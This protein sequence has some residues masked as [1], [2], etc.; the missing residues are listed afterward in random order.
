MRHRACGVVIKRDEILMVRHVH[1]GRDYWTLPGGGIDDGESIFD[2][3]VREVI[4][5]TGIYVD[6]IKLL[7]RYEATHSLS[8]CVLMTTPADDIAPLLGED[9]EESHL[10]RDERMLQ[11]VA[12][13]KIE[14]HSDSGM[15]Q[16]VLEAL[17][18]KPARAE[19]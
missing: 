18:A 15:I 16:Q 11:E 10:S 9:P 4:E 12:W 17:E 1:S 2:A 3:A 6:P 13:Q 14:H 7:C 19:K 5:E 8:E